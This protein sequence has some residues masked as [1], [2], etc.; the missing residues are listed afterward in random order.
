MNI[1]KLTRVPLRDVWKHEAADFTTWLEENFDILNEVL[2]FNLSSVEREKST[3]DFNVDLVGE[4]EDG[5][6]VVIENQLERSDHDH[7]GKVLTYLAGFEAKAAVWIV[8]KPR[9]EHVKVI[10]W[11]NEAT[12]TPFYLIQI[13]AI[14]IGESEPAP[15]LTKIVG[16]SLES[17]AVGATRKERSERHE[18]RKRFWTM[19]L[20]EA[21]KT[22]K[23]HGNSTPT[24]NAYQSATSSAAKISWVYAVR[25]HDA[26]VEL[27]IDRDNADENSH[28]LSKLAEHKAKIEETFG[29][30]LEWQSLEGRRACR[31]RFR[32]Q[33][34]GWKDEEKWP[35]SIQAAIDAMIRLHSALQPHLTDI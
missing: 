6:T 21:K 4:D 35:E 8:A 34:G 24:T 16:P 12:S 20:D 30:E 33:F 19:L 7:L 26:Q 2:D 14:R 11:L 5:N 1:G 10:T 25:Q 3:G 22:T 28:I 31:I 29:D 17:Q 9:P 15:L 13:E 23:L 32:F 27:Y 18:I